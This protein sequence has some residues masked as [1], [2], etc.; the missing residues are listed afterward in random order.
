MSKYIKVKLNKGL[1]AAYIGLINSGYDLTD[2]NDNDV[3][4]LYRRIRKM[5]YPQSVIDYFANARTNQNK[6]NPYWPRGY[7]LSSA[8]FFISTKKTSR[9]ETF[10]DLTQFVHSLPNIDQKEINDDV[11]NWLQQLPLFTDTIIGNDGFNDLWKNYRQINDARSKNYAKVLDSAEKAIND[12]SIGSKLN[13]PEI[14]FAP[15]LL[16]SPYI[17]DHVI[18]GNKIIII[19]TSPDILSIIHEYLHS[20][21]SL[22]REYFEEY[23]RKHDFSLIA[24]SVKLLSSG[25]MWNQS[26]EAKINVLEESFVRGLSI[27]LTAK[28]SEIRQVNDSVN[29]DVNS[30]FILVPLVAQTARNSIP[31]SS[32][33]SDF[34]TAVMDSGL[35]RNGKG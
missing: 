34:M 13:R 1:F 9:Y 33:L 5:N 4:K 15:N 11:L 23:V 32:N 18:K 12:F 24:D 22:Q 3:A 21:I 19:K 29:M 27:A 2:K 35:R 6:V 8:C 20:V 30:G 17:A 31:N 28:S 7:L 25:Y 14:I 10:D 26:K 16:Q